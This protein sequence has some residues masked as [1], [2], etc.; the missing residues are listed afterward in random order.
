[1]ETN[2]SAID[3]SLSLLTLINNTDCPFRLAHWEA[4]MF[5]SSDSINAAIMAVQSTRTVFA[6]VF[7]Y[8]N[9]NMAGAGEDTVWL[10]STPRE[11]LPENMY[12]MA[13]VSRLAWRAVASRKSLWLFVSLVAALLFVCL[14]A[15]IVS[16]RNV[17]RW[18]KRTGFDLIL[19]SDFAIANLPPDMLHWTLHPT[20]ST[21]D[22]LLLRSRNKKQKDPAGW[23]PIY[24]RNAYRYGTKKQTITVSEARLVMNLP[25]PS[26]RT[27][28]RDSFSVPYYVE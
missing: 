9:A 20:D 3:M 18:P 7:H 23:V 4:V 10:R 27:C 16:H 14:L 6:L 11:G 21:M 24:S 17:S 28:S 13:T 22:N 5:P 2:Y 19:K 26:C 25:I 15:M 8:F 12:T 1:M